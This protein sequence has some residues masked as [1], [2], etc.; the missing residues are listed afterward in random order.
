MGEMLEQGL[1]IGLAILIL[2]IIGTIIFF[3]LN[4]IVD[5]AEGLVGYIQEWWFNL[6]G[7]NL[8]FCYGD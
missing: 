6:M 3:I 5:V 4:T 1:V 8:L 2:I 7:K